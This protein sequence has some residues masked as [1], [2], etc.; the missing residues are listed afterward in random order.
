MVFSV[1]RLLDDGVMAWYYSEGM[2]RR[3]PSRMRGRYCGFRPLMVVFRWQTC[4]CKCLPRA[5]ET[6]CIT[7]SPEDVSWQ[8]IVLADLALVQ[9]AR[10]I[11]QLFAE[12]QNQVDWPPYLPDLNL[13]DFDTWSVLEAK[14]LVKLHANLDAQYC[15]RM[16]LVSS[17]INL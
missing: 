10:T 15:R 3:D 9:T 13:P 1:K 7:L 16:V 4:Q 17:R 6:A 5:F 2:E 14:V 11:Q 8:K 12:L